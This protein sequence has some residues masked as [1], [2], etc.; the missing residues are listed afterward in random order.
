MALFAALAAFTHA[1]GG[2]TNPGLV[3]LVQGLYQPGY[4]RR[5]ATYDLRRLR[6]NGLIE[7]L[8]GTHTYRVTDHGRRIATLFT[9]LAAR[10]V[11]PALTDLERPAQPAGPRSLTSAW[12][13]YE[14]EL[15]TLIRTAGLAA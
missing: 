6:R 11:V 10:I 1:V 7:R 12:R 13:A 9:K 2:L 14:H 8:A 5:Q 4:H 3:R 15:Q